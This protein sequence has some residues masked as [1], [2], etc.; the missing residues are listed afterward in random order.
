M[1]KRAL[2]VL[3]RRDPRA[4]V[5][6]RGVRQRD[7]TRKIPLWFYEDVAIVLMLRKPLHGIR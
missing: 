3:S 1:D 7:P 4:A 6:C 2:Q 5:F